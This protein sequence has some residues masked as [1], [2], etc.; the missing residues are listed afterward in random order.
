MV[1]TIG[2]KPYWIQHYQ[3]LN[4]GPDITLKKEVKALVRGFPVTANL[5]DTKSQEFSIFF[6]L[7][8]ERLTDISV[9]GDACMMYVMSFM[10]KGASHI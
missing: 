8:S 6:S 5:W 10:N 1:S 2:F 9:K 4:Y 3:F 7:Q